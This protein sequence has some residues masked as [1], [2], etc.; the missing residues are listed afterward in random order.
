MYLTSFFLD[1]V[2]AGHGWWEFLDSFNA[3][4]SQIR[5]HLQCIALALRCKPMGLTLIKESYP[6][7]ADYIS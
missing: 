5:K 4:P 2:F 7:V 1:L 3:A 6:V